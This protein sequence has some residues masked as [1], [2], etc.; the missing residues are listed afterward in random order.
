MFVARISFSIYYSIKI[1][2]E[3]T[4]INN[5]QEKFSTLQISH[6][7]LNYQ[8]A[9]LNSLQRIFDD[10]QTKQLIPIKSTIDLSK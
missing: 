6:Q 3:N 9:K 8:L 2:D 4:T 5:S 7:S 10:Q 1:V